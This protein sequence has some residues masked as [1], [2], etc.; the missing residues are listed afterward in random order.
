M[1]PH[2]PPMVRGA[3][4]FGPD[5]LACTTCHG[6][7][8]VSYAVEAGSIPGHEPWQLAPESMG[9]AG[10][11]L[12]QI[13]T[14]LKDPERNGGRD[15]EAVWEHMA[16]DGLVGWAWEPGEGRSPAPGNQQV[17]GELTRAWIETGAACPS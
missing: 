4:D 2:S 7:E 9:W 17:F 13:C 15:L 16:N 1:R 11:P 8:N 12:A 5:G 14:Q 10:M 6:S 3:A